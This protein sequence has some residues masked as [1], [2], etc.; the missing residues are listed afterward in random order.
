[1]WVALL[2]VIHGILRVY[3]DPDTGY[4]DRYN[5]RFSP[6]LQSKYQQSA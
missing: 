3:P 5:P 6:V 4:P 1:M 2:F